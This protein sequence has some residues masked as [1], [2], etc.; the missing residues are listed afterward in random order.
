MD[1]VKG[2]GIIRIA[3]FLHV[4]SDHLAVM[5]IEEAAMIQH[6]K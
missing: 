6:N 5:C 1:K 2:R 3:A 4:L